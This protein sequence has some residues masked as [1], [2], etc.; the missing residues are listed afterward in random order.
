MN[1]HETR[2][3]RRFSVL[4]ALGA[5]AVIVVPLVAGVAYL[6]YE[7]E[8]QYR[9]RYR[10][11]FEQARLET[12]SAASARIARSPGAEVE[13]LKSVPG[14]GAVLA[15]RAAVVEEHEAWR[16]NEAAVDLDRAK[17]SRHEVIRRV[18]L[19]DVVR[20]WPKTPAAEEAAELL[21]WKP[22]R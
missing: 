17:E 14:A 11:D 12:A 16:R 2:R 15:A 22:S 9:D 4:P 5:L 19:E 10:G 1:S 21:E 20:E 13:G 8:R 6:H 3:P 7:V 18:I